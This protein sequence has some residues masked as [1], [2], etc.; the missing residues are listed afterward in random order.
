MQILKRHSATLWLVLGATALS[1][2]ACT[3][4]LDQKN[5]HHSETLSKIDSLNAV[6]GCEWTLTEENPADD[7]GTLTGLQLIKTMSVEDINGALP[8]GLPKAKNAVD[9]YKITYAS[10][11]LDGSPV[12]LSGLVLV[13][14]T[15]GLGYPLISLQH[16][17]IF[18]KDEAP[19]AQGLEGYFE[20]SQGFVV[21]VQ[22]YHGFGDD[23]D[24]IHPYL[25]SKA[26]AVSG[27][28]MLRA[29]KQL[30]SSNQ[31][32]VSKYLFLKGYSEGG[33]ATLALQREIEGD[34][35]GEFEITA[36]APAAG[37]YDLMAVGYGGLKA[38]IATPFLGMILNAYGTFITNEPS[39]AIFNDPEGWG[40]PEIYRGNHTMVDVAGILP[41]QTSELVVAEY[42]DD[43]TS[44]VEKSLAGV[45]FQLPPL[46]LAL[47][48]NNL[49][50]GWAPKSPTR[51]YHCVDD[52]VVPVLLTD[53]AF[54]SLGQGMDHISIEKIESPE[55]AP[56]TH[57]TCP[58]IFSSLQWFGEILGGGSTPTEP[59]EKE[60]GE[61]VGGG[62]EPE[63]TELPEVE[64]DDYD[65]GEKTEELEAEK[66]S[67][68]VSQN[69]AQSK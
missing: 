53:S 7:R 17:T 18:H 61:P 25:I 33:Y 22:D 26:Y 55:G 39:A 24:A 56:F 34:P 30:A 40:I 21:A 52:E 12:T 3:K 58:A 19:T 43:F 67:D 65:K 62:S 6:D 14:G 51:F 9:A 35:D 29:T 47:G 36:S 5:A 15:C 28:D 54:A 2:V 10:Q 41:A 66:A 4:S 31:V 37:P 16:A 42:R 48:A 23:A 8:P 59:L 50:V 64:S 63:V 46:A 60:T 45:E 11:N 1:G 27:I 49:H 38:D 20:A 69:P 68:P 13:P 57:A 32:D 44:N